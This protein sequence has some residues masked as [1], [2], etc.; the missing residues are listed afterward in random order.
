MADQKTTSKYWQQ[1]FERLKKEQMRKA[2]KVNADLK[3]VY[4]YTLR[5]L[6]D[7]VAA[8][9]ARYADENGMSLADVRKQL[10]ARELKAFKLTLKQFEKM[11]KQEDLPQEYQKMLEQASIR[12]RQDRSQAMYIKTVQYVERLAKQQ[13]ISL[14]ELLKDVYKDSY[15]KAAYETQK[16]KGS[17]E[18]YTRVSENTIEKAISRPWAEDGK[19]FS[20]RIWENK[21]KLINTLQ[22]EMT[23]SLMAHEPTST[24]AERI[25]KRFN[26][27]FSNASRLVETETA[28]VQE[29]AMMDTWQKLDV[30]QYQILATLD[31]RTTE[32]CR[33][34]D[35]KIFDRKDAKTGITMP[36]FHCYC[37]TTTVLYIKGITDDEDETRAARKGGNGPTTH[38]LAKMKYP[39]WKKIYV[40]RTLSMDS[41]IQSNKS[42]LTPFDL[43]RFARMKP[44]STVKDYVLGFENAPVPKPV[45][46]PETATG[47][48]DKHHSEHAKEMGIS[49]KQWKQKAADILNDEAGEKYLDWYKERKRT[50]NRLIIDSKLLVVG[51]T[52]GEIN[53]FFKLDKKLLKSYLPKEY[54]DKI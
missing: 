26:V 47:G 23:R 42:N 13:G 27:S 30:D 45:F 22:S 44:K 11:A 32:T 52:D 54:L 36:P 33:H 24:L 17:Y 28:Y 12:V 37:R 53:T 40:D 46:Y 4:A 10:D 38:V 16:A 5:K 9:Y 7:D 3:D 29:S 25:A 34:L 8:W 2:E 15:Y 21:T 20:S 50:F 6:Q 14:E 39:D 31:N 18:P 1:R 35:G 43:Q 48:H 41:W 51:S 49:M 19:D